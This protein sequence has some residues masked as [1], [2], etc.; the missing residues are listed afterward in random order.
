MLIVRKEMRVHLTD[1]S[2]E[3]LP[4][5]AKYQCRYPT[6]CIM[7]INAC[8]DKSKIR[9]GTYHLSCVC[10]SIPMLL[11][12][13]QSELRRARNSNRRSSSSL[14]IALI[15]FSMRCFGEMYVALVCVLLGELI[16]PRCVGEM[17]V[18]LVCILFGE[19]IWSLL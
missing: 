15:R 11:S 1:S 8:S 5:L 2:S 13:L 19:L 17:Y 7:Y 10:L 6:R 3:Y 9:G 18:T 4:R 14:L 16:R 12:V